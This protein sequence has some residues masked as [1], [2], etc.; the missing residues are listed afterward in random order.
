MRQFF[1]IVPLL[2]LFALDPFVVSA[3]ELELWSLN[4][5]VSNGP[6]G[7]FVYSPS[8][9][10]TYCTNIFVRYGDA[11]LMADSATVDAKSGDVNS[12]GHVRIQSGG[13]L[14]VGEHISYNFKTKQMRSEQFRTGKPP[15]FAE[16]MELQG[17]LTNKNYNARHVFVTTDDISDPAIKIRAS[18]I[19]MVPGKYVEMWNAVLYIDGVPSFF[20][21]Y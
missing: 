13:Q 19:K 5:I 21:K 6:A 12:D 18:R 16:G 17:N 7:N 2:S 4:Q 3:Q 15:V 1:T 20:F 8:K 9:D 10:L 14:W 11:T